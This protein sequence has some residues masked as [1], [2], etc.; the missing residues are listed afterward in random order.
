MIRIDYFAKRLFDERRRWADLEQS[1]FVKG[2]LL[3]LQTARRIASDVNFPFERKPRLRRHGR[4]SRILD[5][6]QARL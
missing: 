5:A 3:G 1:E 6:H 2:V 4:M